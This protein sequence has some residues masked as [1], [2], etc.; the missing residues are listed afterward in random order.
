MYTYCVN[1]PLIYYDPT[2][3]SPKEHDFYRKLESTANAELKANSKENMFSYS[4]ASG[5]LD[6]QKNKRELNHVDIYLFELYSTTLEEE[7]IN[8]EVNSYIYELK[9]TKGINLNELDNDS[10]LYKWYHKFIQKQTEQLEAIRKKKNYLYENMFFTYE[11]MDNMYFFRSLSDYY[12]GTTYEKYTTDQDITYDSKRATS[13]NILYVMG[14]FDRRIQIANQEQ[15]FNDAI[16]E[17][18]A[19]LG[20]DFAYSAAKG[21]VVNTVRSTAKQS[22]K[23]GISQVNKNVGSGNLVG[24]MTDKFRGVRLK[25]VHGAV[26]K[27]VDNAIAQSDVATLTALG[28]GRG[29]IAQVLK[30]GSQAAKFRGSIID[31]AV[32]NQASRTFGLKSLEMA[33]RFQYGPDFWNPKTMR[34]WD[35]TTSKQWDKHVLKYISN[36]APS[37]PT[38][39]SLTGLFH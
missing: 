14:S 22:A 25:Q 17:T 7:L 31:T 3:H 10:S 34:A 13:D 12:L 11:A 23:V 37:K 35:L 2:G 27:Q 5:R 38:W 39:R 21:I 16:V 36:P 20:I 28:A 1:N 15:A 33:K 19:T 6:L 30:G 32:K 9:R 4:I 8:S 26:V 18:V 29:E 24:W